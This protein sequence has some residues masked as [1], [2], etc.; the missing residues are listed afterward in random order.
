MQ[1]YHVSENGETRNIWLTALMTTTVNSH[2]RNTK[3]HMWYKLE[4]KA[5]SS[6]KYSQVLGSHI[7]SRIYMRTG[8]MKKF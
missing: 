4:P 1:S 2:L 8:H 6:L 5:L 7:F 3:Q